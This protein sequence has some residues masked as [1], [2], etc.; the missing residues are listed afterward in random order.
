MISLLE[1]LAAQRLAWSLLHFLWQGTLLGLLAWGTL[2]LLRRRRPQLRY[3]AGCAFLFACLGTAMA[4]YA[5]LSPAPHPPITDAGFIG[6]APA[7]DQPLGLAWSETLTPVSTFGAASLPWRARLQPYLP[8]VLAIWAVG[9]LLLS[10]RAAGGWLWLRRLKALGTPIPQPEWFE[11][12]VRK[13]NLR[14]AV[15]F[16]E[17]ARVVTPMCMGLLRPVILLP[18]GFFAHLDPLAAEAVL[19]H[20]LAHLRRLDGLVN[21]LQCVIEVLFFFHPAVWWISRRIRTE[22]E[23]CC[24]DAAVLVC[25]DAVYYAE[26]LSRLDA[27][28]DRPPSLALSAKGGNLVERLRRLLLAD[29]PQ[30]RFA[31]PSL[32]LLAALLLVGSLPAQAEKPAVPNYETKKAI[33]QVPSQPDGNDL[34]QTAPEVTAASRFGPILR[35]MALTFPSRG[36][37]EL[38]AAP[39]EI[40]TPM[41]S[42]AAAMPPSAPQASPKPDS[43]APTTPTAQP[44]AKTQPTPE[45]SFVTATKTQGGLPVLKG[46]QL[47]IAKGPGQGAMFLPPYTAIIEDEIPEYR[48][49]WYAVLVP[50]K[51]TIQIQARSETGGAYLRLK[52][53][54]WAANVRQPFRGYQECSFTNERSSEKTIIFHLAFDAN[55]PGSRKVAI[56]QTLTPIPSG[57]DGRAP[58]DIPPS[59]P[60]LERTAPFADKEPTLEEARHIIQT[61]ADQHPWGD[62]Y[63][64]AISEVHIL[65]RERW[66]DAYTGHWPPTQEKKHLIQAIKHIDGWVVTFQ[67]QEPSK[68]P[69]TLTVLLD[70]DGVIHWRKAWPML[71]YGLNK[72]SFGP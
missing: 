17:S 23:H 32:T 68:S 10:F 53:S 16:L 71:P 54:G 19:A 22:R 72:D 18:L 27:L 43:I 66:N 12:L 20:E 6:A 39:G 24:D 49:T 38:P 51:T 61:Y 14:R 59:P 47:P 41:L 29:P 58:A 8:W 55:Y 3:A 28:R 25:G 4:T 30:L 33:T 34:P 63:N 36:S 13:A 9:V 65:G 31:T 7:L 5:V 57:P 37:V 50:P 60:P 46:R 26:I 35:P 21:G 40:A 69:R 56:H 15:R 11:R 67:I 1:S 48:V 64:Q 52:P 45:A 2:A 42:R 44:P 62:T 70:K